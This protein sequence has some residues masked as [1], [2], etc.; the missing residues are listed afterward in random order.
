MIYITMPDGTV[1]EFEKNISVQQLIAHREDT[2]HIYAVT[3]NGKLHD[4][5]YNIKQ[6]GIL[7]FIYDTSETGK[8]IYDRTLSFLF[9]V[10]V[11]LLYRKADVYIEHALSQGLYCTIEKAPCLCL[12]DVEKIK[13]K[14]QELIVESKHIKRSVVPTKDAVEHFEANGMHSKAMLLKYRKSTS[15]SMYTLCGINDYFYGIML[16]NTSYI[17]H[18]SIQHYAPGIW[19]S[20]G[21]QW[22]EQNKLFHVFQEF[23]TWGKLIGV[24]NVAQ[25]NEKIVQ[26]D[27]D[28]LVLMSETM[29]EKKLAELATTIVN[30]HEHIKFILIAGPSSAGKTTFSRRLAIH[31][32]IL[33][34]KPM[35]ISMDDFY[36]NR[37][38][39]PKFP[40][41]SYDFEALEAIDLKLFNDV[42][43]KLSHHEGVKL[44]IY[45]FK[46]GMREWREEATILGDDQILIIEGIHGLNPKTSQYLPKDAKYK[47]YINALT[48]LNLDA[49]NRIA[50]SEYRLIRRI[51]RD[52]QFRGRDA[53]TTI[54]FWKNV[55]HGEET[56][57]YP[58]QNE[59][60]VIF[61]SSM[62]YELSVLK[63]IVIPLLEEVGMEKPEYLEANR[64]KKL[65]A[66]FVEGTPEIVPRNS[67]LAEFIG[68]S[69]F[70]VS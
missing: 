30:S 28:D 25:L 54:H 27:M 34:K 21:S 5:N 69:V 19:I 13:A 10:A 55:R 43:L 44:P 15:S 18:F 8:L 63:G 22:E 35:A 66:Y 40:D 48:H 29:I 62:V 45:N 57:I 32:K 39:T 4:I 12:D 41:G 42:M 46:T 33:G 49:H 68:N 56:Y 14:M 26:G 9:I 59:A 17:T 1:R 47:I 20:A 7:T 61:N 37:E 24:S 2:E 65:L 51:V 52:Y 11:K 53:C 64:L 50:T 31:L 16:P 23:E 60:N 3:L 70:D 6:S 38:D 67:I 36:R 58:Y